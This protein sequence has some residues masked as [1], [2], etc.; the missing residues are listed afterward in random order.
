MTA[1][2]ARGGLGM[3][4]LAARQAD[5]ARKM[6]RAA[7]SASYRTALKHGV[8]AGSEHEHV[9]RGL[10]VDGI[11]DVGANRGQF[12]LVASEVFPGRPIIA[13]EPLPGPAEIFRRVLAGRAVLHECAVGRAEGELE[14]FETSDDNSSSV[15]QPGAAQMRLSAG[16]AV[17]AKRR[18][19]VRTLDDVTSDL[20]GTDLLLKLDVQGF[21]MEALAGAHRLL[22]T[23]VRYVYVE[24]SFTELY[25][26]QGLAHEVIRFLDTEEFDLHSMANPTVCHGQILQADFLFV[27]RAKGSVGQAQEHAT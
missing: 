13:I 20:C 4:V 24:A 5:R 18:V 10:N 26:G 15:L 11:I 23:Q 14:I 7:S 22:T 2:L 17:V 1:I 21:E 9:L 8:L 3:G 12:S 25:L 27:H 6:R 19:R 16:S